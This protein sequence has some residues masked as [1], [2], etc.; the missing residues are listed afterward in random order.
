[1]YLHF[2]KLEQP[3]KAPYFPLRFFRVPVSHLGHG[4]VRFGVIV[5]AVTR[6]AFASSAAN[7]EI[8]F[9]FESM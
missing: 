4:L 1:M 8:E 5:L 6:W 3:R 9:W 7:G 2:G